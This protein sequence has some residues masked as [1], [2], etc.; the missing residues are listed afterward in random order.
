MSPHPA[1]ASLMFVLRGT[2][3]LL[4]AWFAVGCH[5]NSSPQQPAPER[6]EEATIGFGARAGVTPPASISAET[7]ATM[8]NSRVRQVEQL[9]AGRFAGV[10]VIPTTSGGFSIRIRG[11][12]TFTG[13]PEPLYVVDGQPVSVVRGRGIDWLNPADI[14]RI[15]ILKDAASTALYGMRGGNGV[16]LITTKRGQ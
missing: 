2:L 5:G 15:D 16:I 12:A 13:N 14:A 7:D 4:A 8:R 10:Q 11:L 1:P 6:D 9:I 3:M